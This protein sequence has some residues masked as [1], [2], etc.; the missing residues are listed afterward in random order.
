M[1]VS[2][3]KLFTVNDIAKG[4]SQRS[5]SGYI[6][7]FRLSSGM[8]RKMLRDDQWERIEQLLPGKATGRGVTAKDTGPSFASRAGARKGC[9]SGLPPHCVARP[10]WNICFST[11]RSCAHTNTRPAPKKSGRP[12][13]RPFAGWIDHQ[14]AC[15]SGFL[16]QSSTS[17]SHGRSDLRYRASGR[18]DQRSARR[19][20]CGRQGLRLGCLCRNHQGAR[21]PSCHST[22]LQPTQPACLRSPYL[23]GPQSDRALLLSHQAIQTHRH[24]LRQTRTV[25]PV[26]RSSRLRFRLVGVIENRP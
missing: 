20:H 22:S 26:L 1:E 3:K 9:G 12:A 5:E 10:T 24:A 23:Q 25:I 19:V 13:H 11:R 8:D 6:L 14:T 4:C 21:Q 2:L 17:H 16:G 7:A 18:T 15:R